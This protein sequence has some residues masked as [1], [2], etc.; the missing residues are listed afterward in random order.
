MESLSEAARL[1]KAASEVLDASLKVNSYEAPQEIRKITLNLGTAQSISKAKD[2]IHARFPFKSYYV[3]DATDSSTT[4][5]LRPNTADSMQ[6]AVSIRKKDSHVFQ[7]QQASAYLEWDAQPGKTM[8]ICFFVSSDFK[9]GT[10]VSEISTSVDANSRSIIAPV[11]VTNAATSILPSSSRSK[12]TLYNDGP[13]TCYLG[14]SGVTAANGIPL[15]PGDYYIDR[16]TAELFG[17][18]PTVAGAAIRV[19]VEA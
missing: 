8:T 12:A 2:P 16:N 15:A 6:D 4:V 17:I 7:F 9:S 13:E 10:Q 18:T 14:P 1:L 11:A 3:E 5:R 19:Q